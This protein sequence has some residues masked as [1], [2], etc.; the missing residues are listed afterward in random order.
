MNG[1][2]LK[3]EAHLHLYG[4]LATEDLWEIGRDRHHKLTER[5]EWFAKEYETVFQKK[6]DWQN[7]WKN[8]QGYDG[9]KSCFEFT[10]PGPFPQFQAKF[11]LLIALNPPTPGDYQLARRVLTGHGK[12]GGTKEYRT[13]LPM[14]LSEMDREQYLLGLIEKIRSHSSST[15]RPLIALSLFRDKNVSDSAYQWLNH[16][17]DKHPWT[18]QHITGIDFCGSEVEHPP[19]LKR[20]FIAQLVKD[21]QNLGR[22][23]QVLYHV[24]EM[25][26]Q[27][28]LAS[29][30]R[31]V[32]ES[33]QYGIKRIGHGMALG[34][35]PF[36]LLGQ[37]TTESIAEFRD[38]IAWLESH[39]S[40]LHEHGYTKLN[41]EWWVKSGESKKMQELIRWNW[42]AEHCE[43]VRKLQTALLP[44][45]KAYDPLI[46]ICATSNMRIGSLEKTTFHPLRTFLDAGLKVCVST[47]DPGI[48]ALSLQSEE[49][50]LQTEFDC[51]DTELAQ[52]EQN[53][54]SILKN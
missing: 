9:F 17:C 48:F 12:A 54:A 5:M 8:D 39:E 37:T 32:V 23:W 2:I 13:F 40:L 16:F 31:W 33:C 21:N 53:A 28:S 47:D 41:R 7:W 15:F 11:N 46:E 51:N 52:F 4:C 45:I 30:A 6:P 29:A 10:K 50:L 1:R 43:H 3:T 35:D 27:I 25:W 44:M 26:D 24:G 42:D 14:Y 18:L 22:A 38:H 49:N 19:R 20:D 36:A 34:V